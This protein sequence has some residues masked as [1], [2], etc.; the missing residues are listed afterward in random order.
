MPKA[1]KT[2][3]DAMKAVRE[4]AKKRCA[5]K[6]SAEDSDWSLASDLDEESEKEAARDQEKKAAS[7][8]LSPWP[9]GWIP[10]GNKVAMKMDPEKVT[11]KYM[12]K[13]AQLTTTTLGGKVK[14]ITGDVKNVKYQKTTIETD[15]CSTVH[16]G[17]TRNPSMSAAYREM[18]ARIYCSGVAKN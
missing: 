9:E 15:L 2:A 3:E 1:P 4:E 17:L 8:A 16:I 10:A 6:D 14:E 12:E 13:V 7:K 11:H 18:G 5:P